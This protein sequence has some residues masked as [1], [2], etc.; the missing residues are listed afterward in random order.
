[1]FKMRKCCNNPKYKT[2]SSFYTYKEKESSPYTVDQPYIY[3][4]ITIPDSVINKIINNVKGAHF[5][6]VKNII[7]NE[8]QNLILNCNKEKRTYVEIQR[9]ENC[10]YIKKVE[11]KL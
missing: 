9:C 2:V 10:G 6:D 4:T 1:M 3:T 8:F 7:H 5:D 11:V